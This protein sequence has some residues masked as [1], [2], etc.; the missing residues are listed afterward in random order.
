MNFLTKCEFVPAGE[1]PRGY[2][3]VKAIL[4]DPAHAA[5][6]E[7]KKGL[8]GKI[9]DKKPELTSPVEKTVVEYFSLYTYLKD[10]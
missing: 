8:L 6:A 9:F 1:I 7:Q 2:R 5:S 4:V 10:V 3:S